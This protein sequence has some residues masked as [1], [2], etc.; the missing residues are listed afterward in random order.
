MAD[1]W[2]GGE[3]LGEEGG[4]GGGERLGTRLRKGK[5]EVRGK[6]NKALGPE[7]RLVLL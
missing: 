5:K 3:G 2:V 4:W 6:W 7:N 1:W